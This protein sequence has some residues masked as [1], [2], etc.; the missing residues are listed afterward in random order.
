MMRSTSNS[1]TAGTSPSLLTAAADEVR[2]ACRRGEGDDPC[3][4]AVDAK[5]VP[6]CCQFISKV[7]YQTSP[8]P[9]VRQQHP[10]RL[11]RLDVDAGG[12]PE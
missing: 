8:D 6:Q 5:R 3:L 11:R 4:L 12:D 7:Q 10:C 2:E 1:H 9:A